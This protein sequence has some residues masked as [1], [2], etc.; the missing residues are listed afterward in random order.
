MNFVPFGEKAMKMAV[1]LYQN[2]AADSFVMQKQILHKLV[3]VS[4]LL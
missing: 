3:T 1:T 2:S 4:F